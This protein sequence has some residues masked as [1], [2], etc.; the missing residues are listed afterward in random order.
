MQRIAD[1][2]LLKAEAIQ[3]AA[4]AKLLEPNRIDYAKGLE[5]RLLDQEMNCDVKATGVLHQTLWLKWGGVN[6]VF[7]HK[8]SKGDWSYY[9]DAKR[10]GFT[11]LTVTNGWDESYS[12]KL[13]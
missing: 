13:N 9:D 10:L 8:I 7:A 1:A 5:N 3:K 4:D 2:K 6:K 11:K 12:W